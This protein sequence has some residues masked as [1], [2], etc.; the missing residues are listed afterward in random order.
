MQLHR[1]HF[2]ENK[3]WECNYISFLLSL[4]RATVRRQWPLL[5]LRKVIEFVNATFKLHHMS[6]ETGGL[7]NRLNW[8][9]KPLRYDSG[10][11]ASLTRRETGSRGVQ[12]STASNWSTTISESVR[13]QCLT[14][15]PF[16]SMN[17]LL[18]GLIVWLNNSV[19]LVS[20]SPYSPYYN[21]TFM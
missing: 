7:K 21:V 4:T 8:C 11:I 10:V 9:S 19:V 6:S 18:W 14:P 13:I 1:C 16:S 2:E 3:V 5:L 12:A 17:H 15:E 20:R